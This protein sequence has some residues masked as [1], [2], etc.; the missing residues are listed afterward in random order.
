MFVMLG[1]EGEILLKRFHRV[2]ILK[3]KEGRQKSEARR[4]TPKRGW[5]LA[6]PTAKV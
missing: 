6:K 5:N 3:L 2:I 4:R 1:G